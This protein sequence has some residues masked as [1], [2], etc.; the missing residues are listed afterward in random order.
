MLNATPD[1]SVD[2]RCG[3]IPLFSGTMGRKGR[4]ISVRIDEK[5]TAR[6]EG[7]TL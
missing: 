7:Q 5:A 3:D 6:K 4:K 2:L 1:S